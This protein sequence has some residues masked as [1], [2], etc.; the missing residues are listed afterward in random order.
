[1]GED[2][3]VLDRRDYVNF[4]LAEDDATRTAGAY[5]GN[6]ER[7]QQVKAKYDPDNLFRVNRNIHPTK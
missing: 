3:A 5:R 4:Q 6:Y 7:L 1:V 2:P